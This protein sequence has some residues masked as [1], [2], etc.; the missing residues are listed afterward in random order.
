MLRLAALLLILGPGAALAC[1]AP[2][3]LVETWGPADHLTETERSLV[4]EVAELTTTD[5]AEVPDF[6]S[7]VRVAECDLNGDPALE[8]V[9]FFETRYTCSLG[10]Y[11]CAIFVIGEPAGSPQVILDASGHR[12]R[13]AGTSNEG[14]HDLIIETAMRQPTVARFDG[15]IYA[16]TF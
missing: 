9:V 16:F 10:I 11:V 4:L 12:V 5:L 15:T 8:T 1:T 6:W 14:W 13:I 7:A 3:G 2:D